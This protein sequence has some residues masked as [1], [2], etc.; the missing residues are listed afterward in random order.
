MK[1]LF[2]II[3]VAISFSLTSFTSDDTGWTLE[4]NENG[5][6]IFTRAYPN[7]NYKEF[8]AV[9]TVQSTLSCLVALKNDFEN[10]P[11]WY[12]ECPEA[13]T[14]KVI[15]PKEGYYYITKKLPWPFDGRDMVIHYWTTQDL[16]DKSV[17]IKNVAE[18]KYQPENKDW[19]RIYDLNGFWKFTPKGNGNIEVVYQLHAEPNGS[20]PAWLANS[21]V[22]DTP[23]NTFMKMKEMIKQPK[24][25]NAKLPD[26]IE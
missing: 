15:S 13:H 14:I 25:A 21:T 17:T 1:Y 9:M 18:G 6:S 2:L 4:K 5:I 7:S 16:S 23:F 19:V 10:Y 8:K 11:A 26:I 3:C 22:V 24:Y 20:I 12:H